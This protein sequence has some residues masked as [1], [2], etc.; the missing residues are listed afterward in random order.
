MPNRDLTGK[1]CIVTGAGSGLGRM[2]AL[3]LSAAG[4]R[5]AGVDVNLEAL[6]AT[7]DEATGAGVVPIQTDIT[8]IED[9]DNAIAKTMSLSASSLLRDGFILRSTQH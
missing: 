9:A 3:G 6:K 5:V 1:V 2:M 8:K 7:A 4:A